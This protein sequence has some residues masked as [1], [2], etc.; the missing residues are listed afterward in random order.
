ML[1]K[2]REAPVFW[3]F[4]VW[5]FLS[6]DHRLFKLIHTP[7]KA[8]CSFLKKKKIQVHA[9]VSMFEAVERIDQN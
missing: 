5:G 8:F 4:S 1:N 6:L 2:R 3:Y 9:S 7:D